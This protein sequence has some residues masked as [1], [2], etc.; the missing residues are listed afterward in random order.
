MS[1]VLSFIYHLPL[2]Y[3]SFSLFLAPHFRKHFEKYSTMPS[4]HNLLFLSALILL[5]VGGHAISG[6]LQTEDDH[7]Q[8]RPSRQTD[9]FAPILQGNSLNAGKCGSKECPS[10]KP[11]CCSWCCVRGSE[12]FYCKSEPCDEDKLQVVDILPHE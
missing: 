5:I 11:Y 10:D 1:F 8:L 2:S 12:I 6:A 3:F 7:R 4:K 9:L